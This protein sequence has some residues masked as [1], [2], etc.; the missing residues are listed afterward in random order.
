MV[1][2]E[3]IKR[4]IVN[5]LQLNTFFV[6]I[7]STTSPTTAAAP[8]NLRQPQPAPEGYQYNQ[9]SPRSPGP[10]YTQLSGGSCPTTAPTPYQWTW[11]SSNQGSNSGG[12]G[13]SGSGPPQQPQPHELSDML[14]MLDQSGATSFED[15]NMFTT[16]F[17]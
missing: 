8:W 3:Q 17:E 13:S 14:Q 16:T 10:T 7:G 11:Q 5:H 4:K 9:T 6:H 12:P 1:T 15:L 2:Y